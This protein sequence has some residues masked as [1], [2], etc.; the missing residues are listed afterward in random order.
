MRG[1]GGYVKTYRS[2]ADWEWFT[3]P[4]TAHLWEYLRVR[5]Q[6]EDSQW[7]GIIIRRGQLL[8][9]IRSIS[10]NTGLSTQSVRT[11]LAH[12]QM[13]GEITCEVT[14]LGMLISI[15]KYADFQD[16]GSETN[17][18]INTQSTHNSTRE[19]TGNQHANQHADQHSNKKLRNKE[20]KEIKKERVSPTL[21]EIKSFV[22]E[23]KLTIDPVRFFNF[24]EGQDWKTASGYPIKDWRSKARAWQSS[25]RPKRKEE[26]P[27]YYNADPI[28]E[29]DP[30]LASKE[31]IERVR[32][33]LMKGAKKE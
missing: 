1:D 6:W 10:T 4:K 9:S 32:A 27:D 13:T 21:E 25:E 11:A 16:L 5:A 23:E 30:Q 7:R 18:Q 15:V 28:R 29:D 22:K 2:I 31:E 3:D 33:L 12:L 26:L 17:T 8:E 20:E 24:Y 14:H 19:L